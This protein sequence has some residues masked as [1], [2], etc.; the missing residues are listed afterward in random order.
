MK[1]LI[2]Q[3]TEVEQLFVYHKESTVFRLNIANLEEVVDKL[4]K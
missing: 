4:G 3:K 1:K 2:S